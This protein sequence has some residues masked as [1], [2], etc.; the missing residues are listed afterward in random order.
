MLQNNLPEA[1]SIYNELLRR[2][3]SDPT[4]YAKLINIVLS[5]PTGKDYITILINSTSL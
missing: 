1:A 2:N 5:S 4:S 3:P